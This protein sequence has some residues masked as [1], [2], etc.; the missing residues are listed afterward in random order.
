MKSVQLPDYAADW[1]LR[2]RSGSSEKAAELNQSLSRTYRL[3]SLALEGLHEAQWRISD[4]PKL[5]SAT[6][7]DFCGLER[8]EFGFCVYGSERGIPQI[9]AIFEDDHLAAK[10]FVWIVS[11]GQRTI[12][13]TKFMEMEP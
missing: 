5:R 8:F 9:L 4:E 10:Y 2:P 7:N 6:L 3:I 13:W 1:M 11:K 12:D